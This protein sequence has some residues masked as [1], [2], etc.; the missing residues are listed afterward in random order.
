MKYK[1]ILVCTLILC[2]STVCGC[3]FGSHIT[4]QSSKTQSSEAYEQS[5]KVQN[6]ELSVDENKE[7]SE[8]MHVSPELRKENMGGNRNLY[9]FI[10][11]GNNT[12]T[13]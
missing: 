5:S 12:R 9:K 3:G 7:Y 8:P 11:S 4:T 1:F 10:I 13:V 2:I 6:I